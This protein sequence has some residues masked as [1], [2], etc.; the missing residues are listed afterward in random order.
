MVGVVAEMRQ[1]FI[2]EENM[3]GDPLPGLTRLGAESQREVLLQAAKIFNRI[4]SYQI[5]KSINGYGGLNFDEKGNVVVGPTSID[6]GGSFLKYE[7]MYRGLFRTQ[8]DIASTCLQVPDRVISGLQR[9]LA[10]FLQ[11]GQIE[12]IMVSLSESKPTLVHGD[13][14]ENEL[15]L[16]P[17]LFSILR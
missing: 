16:F 14:G 3:R 4:H 15:P 1:G 10:K 11:S 13:F 5:S 7:N 12:K 2:I 6:C 17:L 9:R 8:M